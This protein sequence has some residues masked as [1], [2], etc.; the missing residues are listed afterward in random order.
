MYLDITRYSFR[1]KKIR[2][3]ILYKFV[4]IEY[5]ILLYQLF[6]L[7]FIYRINSWSKLFLDRTRYIRYILPI[8]NSKKN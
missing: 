2:E 3:Y 8:N 4:I 6:R 1:R 5:L 7:I